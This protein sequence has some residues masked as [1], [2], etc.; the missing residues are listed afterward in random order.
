MIT[1]QDREAIDEILDCFD[2]YKVEQVMKH[3]EWKWHSC[4]GVPERWDLRK[5][6]RE[7]LEQVA[8]NLNTKASEYYIGTGGF[9]A[10]GK[11]YPGDTKK[12]LKLS[13]VVSEWDNYD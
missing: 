4:G 11:L 2:F 5:S 1:E 7:S 12:Y 3:L 8:T 6:A 9:F 13:F 10:E